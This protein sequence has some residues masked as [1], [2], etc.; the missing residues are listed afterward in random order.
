M[1]IRK[2]A[3]TIVCCMFLSI[4]TACGVTKEQNVESEEGVTGGSSGIVLAGQEAPEIAGI[5]KNIEIEE[6]II[7]VE[8]QDVHYHLSEKA[9]SQLDAKEVEIGS[10]VTFTTFSIGDNKE[11]IEAFTIK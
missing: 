7:T 3:V 9:K 8:G 2:L 1:N 4:L 5:I 11:T 10:T 6:I